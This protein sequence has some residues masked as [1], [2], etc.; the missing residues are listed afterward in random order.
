MQVRRL[1]CR[2][3][4]NLEAVDFEPGAEFNLLWGDNA[5][6][7]TNCLEALYL[8]GNLKSFRPARNDELVR[9]DADGCRVAVSVEGGGSSHRLDLTVTANG[10]SFRLDEK[11]VQRPEQLLDQLRVILFV[12]EEI[13][14]IRGYPQARRAFLD[15]AV[16]QARPGYLQEAVHYERILRQR[17]RLLREQGGEAQLAPWNEAL[18]KQGAALRSARSRF[19]AQLRPWFAQA[20]AAIGGDDEP[21]LQLEYGSEQVD[22]AVQQQALAA[23]LSVCA[24]RERQS[25]QTL[26]GPHR[27]DLAFV[28][29]E[30]SLRQFGSQGQLRTALLA[31]KAAQVALLKELTGRRPL[32]L[33]DDLT[34]ELDRKRQL[35]FFH[36][37]QGCRGQVFITTTVAG[38]LWTEDLGR[39]TCFHVERGQVRTQPVA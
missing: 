6:G 3:F 12:P 13:G 20:H 4:R 8:L 39:T 31:F 11:V 15:R 19:L 26:A 30:R 25:G 5:Q 22:E 17:N 33:L 38:P 35:R 18:V 7:K 27:D 32:L 34:S 1:I 10:K 14:L 9:R 36:Y 28:L 23:E 21:P 24:G 2:N 37:L 29:A 16:F